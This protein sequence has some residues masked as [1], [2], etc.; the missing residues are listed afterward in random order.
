MF[1]YIH[2]V[3]ATMETVAHK[4]HVVTGPE[5]G[6]LQK[7]ASPHGCHSESRWPHFLTSTQHEFPPFLGLHF[8]VPDR[9]CRLLFV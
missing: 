4:G 9:T 2:H 3:G 7:P 5:G 8:S 6:S 1:L